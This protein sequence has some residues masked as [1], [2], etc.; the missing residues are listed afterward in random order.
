LV[1]ADKKSLSEVT[2]AV[3]GSFVGRFT[4]RKRKPSRAEAAYRAL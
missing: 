1:P 3:R 4:T 2:V